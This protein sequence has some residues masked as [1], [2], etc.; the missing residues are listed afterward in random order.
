[1]LFQLPQDGT[2]PTCIHRRSGPK[3]LLSD[4]LVTFKVMARGSK[5]DRRRS[6]NTATSDIEVGPTEFLLSPRARFIP[7]SN[8]TVVVNPSQVGERPADFAFR[9][10]LAV[11]AREPSAR[12]W[13]RE[14]TIT[15]V[16]GG[17]LLTS[18]SL[19][20]AQMGTIIRMAV[21]ALRESGLPGLENLRP[22]RESEGR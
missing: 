4:H 20:R 3:H 5:G 8:Y 16:P 10:R 15:A 13:V 21:D 9:V 18:T 22:A 12:A 2:D 17:P 14:L 7:V 1:M 19:H 6:R 11:E